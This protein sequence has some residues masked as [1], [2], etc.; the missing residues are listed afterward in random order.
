MKSHESRMGVFACRLP[1]S[2]PWA[3][4][5]FTEKDRFSWGIQIKR[6]ADDRPVAGQWPVSR[7]ASRL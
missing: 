1:L 7:F 4:W 2:K 6:P 3:R 5:V